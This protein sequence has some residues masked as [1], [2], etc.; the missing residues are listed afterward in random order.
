VSSQLRTAIALVPLFLAFCV[1]S[2]GGLVTD[3]PWGDVGHYEGFA[4]RILDGDV[5]YGDFSVEYPPFA[6]PAF[7]AP[8][9]VTST[10][11]DYLFAFKL[12]MAGLG[13]VVLVTTGYSLGRLHADRVATLTGLG[14]I[15]FAPLLL[16]HVFLNRY[17]L[18]PAALVALAIA[19]YL[20]NRN[21]AASAFLAASFAAK[22]FT[23]AMVPLAA[24]RVLLQGRT[25]LLRSAAAFVAVCLAIYGYFLAT[26]FGGLGF[27]Y[28]T[29]ASRQLHGES[30]AGSVLLALDTIGL[31]AA[32]IVPGDPGSLDLAGRLPSL[33]ATL[34]TIA[35][36]AAIVWVWI[37]SRHALGSDIV[38]VT[39]L[40]AAAVAFLALAKV[41]SPQFLTWLLPLVPL[42]KGRAGRLAVGLL[43]ASMVLTQF[44]LRGWEGL[45]VDPWAVWL[46]LAR[47]VLL[48]LLLVIL[49]RELSRPAVTTERIA[50]SS[51]YDWV[52][53]R[54]SASSRAR[55]SATSWARSTLSS[56]S[57]ESTVE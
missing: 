26:S 20:S 37:A 2:E 39:S 49:A 25:A 54:S 34:T 23:V 28:W 14:A 24:W 53:R 1:F 40:A 18:W 21:T 43:V 6:L 47:N 3:S 32:T 31:Y 44:E 19:G 36:G 48:V 56:V 15:A 9:L 17:D 55:R 27:S 51:L 7:V 16:G 38:F 57:R 10:A 41:I 42:L 8:A 5:P 45:H 46:L 52:F 29:Q 35:A 11:P 13:V 12:L 33:L 30:L 4:R 22:T 50:G